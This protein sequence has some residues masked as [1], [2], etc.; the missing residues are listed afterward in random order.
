LVPLDPRKEKQRLLVLV[1]IGLLLL[2]LGIGTG[3]VI[4][5]GWGAF[6]QSHNATVE[7]LQ[8]Q[9]T[10]TRQQLAVYRTDKT[11]ANEAQDKVQQQYKEL[12]DQLAELQEAVIFYKNIMDPADRDQGLHIEHLTVH[13]RGDN[14]YDFNLVLIQVGNNKWRPSLTGNV[15]WQL[16]GTQ[17]GKPVTLAQQVFLGDDSETQFNFRYFQELKGSLV[18]PKG[19]VPDK[20]IIGAASEGQHAYQVQHTFKWANVE[21]NMP[22]TA[23]PGKNLSEKFLSEK[24]NAG[25]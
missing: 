24:D 10:D 11:I 18:L 12:R 1:G 13:A 15:T 4:S 3:L 5:E 20:I 9:L 19:V 7:S 14:H 8:Q 16:I 22:G 23:L 2:L 6:W 25:S 21:N 17:N